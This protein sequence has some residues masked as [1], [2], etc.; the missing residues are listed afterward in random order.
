MFEHVGHLNYR[1]YMQTVQHCLNDDGLFLL[2]TI[3]SNISVSKADDWITK[4]IFPNG[5]LPS[6]AQIG[7]ASEKLFI[8]EDWHNFGSYYDKTLMAW[9]DNF[10]KNWGR[11]KEKYDE[12]FYRM[13]TY[14]LLLSAGGFRARDMQLWQIVFSKKGILG[15]Y[16]AQR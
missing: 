10:K 6:V 4:Y 8:M 16:E 2:H 3:G 12:Q 13:W 15:G 9:H 5:M 7:K 1:T 11:L 14:Y